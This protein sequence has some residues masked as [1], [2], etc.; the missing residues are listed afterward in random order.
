MSTQAPQRRAL[1]GVPPWFW[2]AY[3]ASITPYERRRYNAAP[4]GT[5]DYVLEVDYAGDGHRDHRLD[6]MAPSVRPAEPMPVYVYFHGGGWTSGDKA[7]LTKYCAIQA[8]AG[9]LVVNVNYRRAGRIHHMKHMLQDA[10]QALAWVREHAAA[11]G[12]DASRIV[13]GGDSAGAQIVSLLAAMSSREELAAHYGITPAVG[14]E[15]IDGLVL[16]CG[17]MDFSVVFEP[18][19]IMGKGFVRML[20]PGASR[21]R[22][23]ALSLQRA[24]RW[25]SPIEWLDERSAPVLVTTSERDIFYRANLNFVAR[26]REHGVPV[27]VLAYEWSAKRTEHTWQ[28]DF[29][30][31]ESQEVYRRLQRFVER[32]SSRARSVGA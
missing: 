5:V 1:F 26:A 21:A 11:F 18:G 19:F 31:P 17:A 15:D 27:E 30:L 10:N 16:H 8:E 14:H 3:L 12:A 6:V 32:V 23:T 25:L 24:S 13:L 2:R 4:L 29:R 9:M 22:R 20:L 7:V 28:Q